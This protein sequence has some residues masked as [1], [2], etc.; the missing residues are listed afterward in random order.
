MAKP[1]RTLGIVLRRFDFMESSRIVVL[2]TRDYGVLSFLAKGAHRPKSAFLGAIDLMNVGEAR[3]RV[4]PGTGLQIIYGFK[5]LRDNRPFCRD[6]KRLAH[7]YRLTELIRMAM[8]EGRADPDLFDLY[9]GGIGLFATAANR[10]LET[11]AAGIELRTLRALGLLPDLDSCPETGRPLPETGSVGFSA[12][13]GGF[14]DRSLGERSVPAALPELAR[15]LLSYDG[16]TLARTEAPAG[17][18]RELRRLIDEM[19]SWHVGT[20]PRRSGRSR[21]HRTGLHG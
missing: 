20:A 6:G 1:D 11:I 13:D 16:V 10:C 15:T 4:R 7:A 9:R 12:K 14:V 5:V 19:F 2:C 21:G 17:R 8:P 3:V 18:L